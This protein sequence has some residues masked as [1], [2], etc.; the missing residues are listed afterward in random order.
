MLC[1]HF[2]RACERLAAS[3]AGI[4]SGALSPALRMAEPEFVR[5]GRDGEIVDVEEFQV[6]KAIIAGA[7][8]A[9]LRSLRGLR[10]SRHGGRLADPWRAGL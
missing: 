3:V 8:Q 5:Y 1:L 2:T 10:P 9:P 4:V 6:A 7:V